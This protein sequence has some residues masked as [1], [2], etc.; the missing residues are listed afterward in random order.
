M[1]AL[2]NHERIDRYSNLKSFSRSA[3][4]KQEIKLYMRYIK[5]ARI[6]GSRSIALIMEFSSRG[7]SVDGGNSKENLRQ[8]LG[9]ASLSG[10]P[11]RIIFANCQYCHFSH[12]ATG[13]SPVY[14]RHFGKYT[15]ILVKTSSRIEKAAR[16]LIYN[17]TFPDR[18]RRFLSRKT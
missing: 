5:Y 4:G 11:A 18:L 16:L 2:E 9:R 15:A 3:M 17:K 10:S 14:G 1:S 13:A 7:Y 8:P 12:L 6:R